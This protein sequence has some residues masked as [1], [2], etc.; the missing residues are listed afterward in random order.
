MRSRSAKQTHPRIW[1]GFLET[2]KNP[3]LSVASESRQGV[4]VWV[5]L[6]EQ[7]KDNPDP[8]V[9]FH[10]FLL[11]IIL[12]HPVIILLSCVQLCPSDM[13]Y[14]WSYADGG[15][16]KCYTQHLSAQCHVEMNDCHDNV[17]W[18]VWSQEE[19][20]PWVEGPSLRADGREGRETGGQWSQCRPQ[21][22]RI[23]HMAKQTMKGGGRERSSFEPRK[24][25]VQMPTQLW[26]KTHESGG[27]LADCHWICTL[28]VVT[29]LIVKI[30]LTIEQRL[31]L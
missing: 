25:Q 4:E 22:S 23:R 1:A 3:G 5:L 30:T 28:A 21:S 27:F 16:T 20:G 11:L 10:I 9:Q 13:W 2:D 7:I 31:T 12:K 17:H 19:F 15:P 8:T 18:H 14:I 24:C 26:I 6:I 29:S